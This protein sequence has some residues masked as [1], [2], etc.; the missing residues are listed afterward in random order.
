MEGEYIRSLGSKGDSVGHFLRPRCI[1]ATSTGVIL[2]SDEENSKVQVCM[3]VCVCMCVCMYVCMCLCILDTSTGVILVSD[4]EN[5]KVQ[6]CMY[7]CVC[8]CVC[9][10]VCAYVY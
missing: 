1:L 4:E 6:V 8:M 9:V 3:Y 2:V 7:V 5:S 10:L